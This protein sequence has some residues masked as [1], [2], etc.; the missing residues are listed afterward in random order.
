MPPV[1]SK[2]QRFLIVGPTGAGK[3]TLFNVLA[4]L[5]PGSTNAGIESDAMVAQTKDHVVREIILDT[6]DVIIMVDTIG[7]GLIIGN[8]VLPTHMRR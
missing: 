4:K 2:P 8:F 3:T 1:L 5:K 6:G 7:L